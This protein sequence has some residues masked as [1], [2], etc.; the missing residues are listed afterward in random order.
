MRVAQYNV[1]CLLA[2][3]AG[4]RITEGPSAIDL[5][6]DP[7]ALD[8][9][10]STR[11]RG[12]GEAPLLD[13]SG[14]VICA[15][16]GADLTPIPDD[17]PDAS[18][19]PAPVR[20][21]RADALAGGDG[22][23]EHPFTTVAEA[24]SSLA[25]SGTVALSEGRFP[26]T[27]PVTVR[28][29]VAFVGVG[30]AITVLVPTVGEVFSVEGGA[31]LTLQRLAIQH[32]A[33]LGSGTSGSLT[34]TGGASLVLRDVA[35]TRPQSAVRASG[36][37]TRVVAD[38][39]TVRSATSHGVALL[40]GAR[41]VL[42]RALVRDS[43]GAG[44]LAGAVATSGAVGARLQLARSLVMNNLGGGVVLRGPA[45]TGGA[46][47]D[48]ADLSASEGAFDCLVDV[49]L[50]DNFGTGVYVTGERRV[51]VR[52][53][54]VGITHSSPEGR[55]DGLY[56]ARGARV[57]LDEQLG[58]DRTVGQGSRFLQNDRAGLLV[59]G[60]GT[61][62][63]VRRALIASNRGPGIVI[64]SGAWARSIDD[65]RVTDN[66]GLGLAV[67]GGARATT[68]AFN[69][70]SGTRFGELSS[71]RE[72]VFVDHGMAMY[73]ASA[74]SIEGNVLS[75][76]VGFALLLVGV[77]GESGPVVVRG[78][79][80]DRNGYR[81]GLYGGTSATVEREAIFGRDPPAMA[82]ATPPPLPLPSP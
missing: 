15:S 39:L 38:G 25:G 7:P 27:A 43:V 6:E 44:V 56:A 49:A 47:C 26:V 69:E 54:H 41:G 42:R 1:P 66:V 20:Y 23:R 24:V 35:V 45:T 11:C 12:E 73:D 79:R 50:Q 28:D 13:G 10:V 33:D 60:E 59:D 17:F 74:A 52:R 80:G 53:V 48:A 71:A 14:G 16:V 36:M 58:R 75:Y 72:D 30:A 81:V 55:G 37:G 63:T 82:P 22:S 32:R 3:F 77:R 51:A 5:Y 31:T 46:D 61:E 8:G 18:S 4:C 19:L 9:Y 70:F 78:N 68:V 34:A 2:L 67:L 62:V 40:D 64:Q 21:V 76:N 29:T 57:Q 65:C